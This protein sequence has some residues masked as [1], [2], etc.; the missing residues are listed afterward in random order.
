MDS[1]SKLELVNMLTYI[2]IPIMLVIFALIGYLVYAYSKNKNKEQIEKQTTKGTGTTSTA[3]NN[4]QNKQSIF[5]FM[6]FDEV[7][8]NMIIQKNHSRFLMAIEC[9]GINY[10]LMSGIEKTSVEEGFVQ[11]LN[12]LRYKIQIYIQTRSIDLESSLEG[13][14]ERVREVETKLN[15]MQMQYQ[16]MLESEEY[17]EE[18]LAKAYFELTKQTNLY[19]YGRS[20]LQDTERMSLNKNILNKKYYII[21]PYFSTEAGSENLDKE[22]LRGIAFSELYTRAQSIIRSISVCGV[23]GKVLTSNE[24]VELLY[25]AYNR[26]EAEVFGLD[27]ALKAGYNEMYS[28]AP[29]V[30][31]KKMKEL[32]KAIEE[33]AIQKAQEKVEEARTEIEKEIDEKEE[34]MDD[35]IAEMAELIIKQNE[36]YIGKDVKD[37]AIEKLNAENTKEGG[38]K[39]EK[40]KSTRS[41]NKNATV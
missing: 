8:D 38:K 2:L 16:Q 14:R 36:K 32:D 19:E 26:D 40:K 39:N 25:M 3:T 20:V 13:Y 30:L 10:D 31:K 34:N 35:I 18:Q 22:E 23:R 4:M 15:R 29:D 6:E 1:Q 37:K 27:K 41:R 11:F 7:I 5:K 17:S 28:T 24:L 21:I 12:S 33:K 9:Q